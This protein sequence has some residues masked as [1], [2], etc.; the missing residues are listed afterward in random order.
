MDKL[1]ATSTDLGFEPDKPLTIDEWVSWGGSPT[2]IP[3][4][5]AAGALQLYEDR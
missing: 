2:D 5:R 4:S 3:A 1:F